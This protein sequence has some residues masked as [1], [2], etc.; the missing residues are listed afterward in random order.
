MGGLTCGGLQ[1]LLVVIRPG[2]EFRE[3]WRNFDVYLLE[4]VISAGL[5]HPCRFGGV[6]L[7][8]RYEFYRLPIGRYNVYLLLSVRPYIFANSV[9]DSSRI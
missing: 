5:T 2:V 9:G 1:C 3:F 7:A 4:V 8:I 6:I